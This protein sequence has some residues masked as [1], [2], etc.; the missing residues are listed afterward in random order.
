MYTYIPLLMIQRGRCVYITNIPSMSI[1]LL[2]V[3]R[4]NE[5][6]KPQKSKGA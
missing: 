2:A 3:R 5:N 6:P 4:A 1:L